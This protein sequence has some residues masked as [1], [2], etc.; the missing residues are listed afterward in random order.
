MKIMRVNHY[1]FDVFLFNGWTNWSRW[2]KGKDGFIKQIS[3]EPIHGFTKNAI[4][5]KLNEVK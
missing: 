1:V 5:H 4:I 2:N 3:G